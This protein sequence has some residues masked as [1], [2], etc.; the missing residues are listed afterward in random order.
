MTPVERFDPDFANDVIDATL[1]YDAISA[2]LGNRFRDALR[3]TLR[4]V[5]QRPLSFGFTRQPSRGAMLPKFPYV[6]IFRVT[7]TSLI[8]GGCFHSSSDPARWR[9]R[10]AKQD[11]R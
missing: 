10:M 4:E 1:Y 9:E 2:A 8:Y 11:G 5:R 7:E 6:V 3:D